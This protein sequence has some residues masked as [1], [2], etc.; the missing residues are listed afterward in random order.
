MAGRDEAFTLHIRVPGRRG[1]YSVSCSLRGGCPITDAEVDL[2]DV[3]LDGLLAREEVAV[4]ASNDNSRL[5]RR[6]RQN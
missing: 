1:T 2:L 5:M 6:P 3:V 4:A